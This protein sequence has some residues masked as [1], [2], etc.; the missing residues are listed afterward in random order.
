M[1]YL[2][3][4]ELWEL[5]HSYGLPS[6]AE[7]KYYLYKILLAVQECHN[8]GI[9]HRDLKP[10]NI[11]LDEGRVDLKLID[12]ATSWDLQNPEK[13]GSGNGSTG[14]RVYYHFVGTPQ[15]MPAEL[16]RNQG[17][18]TATDVYAIGCIAYQLM[19]GFPPFIGPGEYQIFKEA[20]KCDLKFYSFM[21]ELEV[22]FL[23]RTIVHDRDKR[24]SIEDL[25]NH[26]Y[27]QDD[28]AWYA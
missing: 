28:L 12:F 6:R 16:F 19:C 10:E 3:G 1:E 18:F 15:Y 2:S 23:S 27:F 20:E 17:S 22:D 9:V 5:C 24:A 26:P 21:N 4:G 13:K 8:K 11:M 14:R 7:I 25:L